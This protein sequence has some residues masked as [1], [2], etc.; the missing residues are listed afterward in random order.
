MWVRGLLPILA[1]TA[2]STDAP[3][4]ADTA[5]PADVAA[6]EIAFTNACAE[7]HGLGAVGTDE[8]PPLV[9]DIYRSSHHADGSISLAISNGVRQHHWD[10]GPMEPVDGLTDSEV[11]SIIAYVRHLQTNAGIE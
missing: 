4:V 11:V 8:G 1:I 2:C 5:T 7:C 3:S 6:G 10:F 9:D